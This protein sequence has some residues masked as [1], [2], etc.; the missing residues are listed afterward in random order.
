MKKIFDRLAV[1]LLG[2]L[3]V[4]SPAL[5]LADASSV[6]S[7]IANPSARITSAC[8]KIDLANQI[9]ALVKSS[10]LD[11][12]TRDNFL[13]Q[14]NAIKQDV[15]NILMQELAALT[16]GLKD[17][18]TSVAQAFQPAV[19]TI[20]SSALVSATMVTQACKQIG[21]SLGAFVPENT[22][23]C[24]PGLVQKSPEGMLVGSRGTCQK[25][26]TSSHLITV[27]SIFP[28]TGQNGSIVTL[29]GSGFYNS[30]YPFYTDS[31]CFR[32]GSTCVNAYMTPIS[33]NQIQFT[34]PSNSN[35]PVGT[36]SLVM[37]S[38]NGSTQYA[39]G[40]NGIAQQFTVVASAIPSVI[41]NVSVIKPD[42]VISS[43][44][45]SPANPKPNDLITTNVMVT[46]NSS[47]NIGTPFAI[48]VRGTIV[49]IDS[50]AA[51]SSKTIS[52]PNAF[53]FA[54][55]GSYTLNFPIDIWN[56]VDESNESNNTYT[57]TLTFVSPVSQPSSYN[58]SI[59]KAG[60]GS[61]TVS[62]DDNKI[63]CGI[64]CSGTYNLGTSA[65]ITATPAFGSV[66]GVWSGATCGEGRQSGDTC[67]LTMNQNQNIIA[68]FERRNRYTPM[69][70][71]PPII[72]LPQPHSSLVLGS[73]TTVSWRI[74]SRDVKLIVGNSVTQSERELYDRVSVI[75]PISA[76]NTSFL[77]NVPDS[78]INDFTQG[79]S[80]SYNQIKDAFF[81]QIKFVDSVGDYNVDISEKI[82]F[83]IEMPHAT[84]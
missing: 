37:Q 36:Y 62:A 40:I 24:C 33:D 38:A 64:T 55:P 2:L 43:T 11:T 27:T 7:A 25:P 81:L 19:K 59:T 14:I 58:L 22:A 6:C 70:I 79:T 68:V 80:Y 35:L 66:F 23:V 32:T 18:T 65:Y 50:L 47:V 42:I 72:I 56:A 78:L 54:E 53:S 21:E 57:T 67:A 74:N 63:N 1:F 20:T 49:T 28:L 46:N 30:Q 10:G 61:G 83:S 15:V 48:N 84:P 31:L 69:P 44:T 16:S 29:T 60:T 3:V 77:W 13:H 71:P 39:D 52:V 82:P 9:E 75:G 12:S 5:V 51:W 4:L 41:T 17:T 26:I 8:Q 45:F 34:V 73:T 76:G